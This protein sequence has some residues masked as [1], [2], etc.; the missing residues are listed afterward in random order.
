MNKA[1]G[2]GNVSSERV[3]SVRSSVLPM[4]L[5]CDM[6]FRGAIKC[7]GEAPGHALCW[8]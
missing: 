5:V 7:L 1:E 3:I 8:H 2:F 4:P 6:I